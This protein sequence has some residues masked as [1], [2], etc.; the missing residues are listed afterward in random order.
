MCVM[1]C[2]EPPQVVRPKIHHP[3]PVLDELGAVVGGA[4]GIGYGVGKLVFDHVPINAKLFMQDRPGHRPKAVPGHLGFRVVAH[5]AQGGIHGGIT[6]ALLRIAACEN[7]PAP[8]REWVQLLQDRHGLRG[9]GHE[10]RR[11]D[12]LTLPSLHA[13]GRNVPFTLF[14]V[15]FG[16]FRLPQLARANEY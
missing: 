14:K 8:A 9:Q 3:A 6:H 1:G 15:D 11:R 10:V 13:F 16:P 4:Q 12:A 7:M 2:L 5:A